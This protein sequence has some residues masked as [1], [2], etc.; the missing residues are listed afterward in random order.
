MFGYLDAQLAERS[1]PD[2]AC[3]LAEYARL[4]FP[5]E[6]PASVSH[7]AFAAA[8]QE[9]QL[10]QRRFWPFRVAAAEP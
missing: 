3:Q 2:Y 5:Q 10:V 6:D 8:E 7:R 4:E 9:P 1:R